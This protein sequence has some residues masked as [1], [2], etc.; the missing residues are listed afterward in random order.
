MLR[1]SACQGEQHNRVQR[2]G[3]DEGVRGPPEGTL[4]HTQPGIKLELDKNMIRT[5]KPEI[6][7]CESLPG[8]LPPRPQRKP[9]RTQLHTLRAQQ[10]GISDH[11]GLF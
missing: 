8:I 1:C 10:D 6:S 3:E 7:F 2:Q 5:Y 4:C 11:Q 9:P